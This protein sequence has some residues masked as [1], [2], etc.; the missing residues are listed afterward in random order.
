MNI[1]NYMRKFKLID[2]Q[3]PAITFENKIINNSCDK[4]EVFAQLFQTSLCNINDLPTYNVNGFDSDNR[5]HILTDINFDITDVISIL[6]KLPNKDGTSPDGISYKIIKNSY[7]ILAPYLLDF[8]RI[9]LDEGKIPNIWKKSIIIP[10][11]KKGDKSN[12]E[13]YRPVSIT[14]CMCRIMEKILSKYITNFL[15]I[16]NLIN[17]NHFGFMQKRSTTTQ[18]ITTLEDWYDAMFKK[19]NIDCIFIDF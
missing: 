7:L 5:K 14:C 10:I 12:P 19:K 4:S 2:N 16:N 11:F 6:K 9:S 1:F 8:F 17:E 15:M 13:N 18:F 3:I